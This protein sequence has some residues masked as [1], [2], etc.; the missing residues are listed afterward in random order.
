M[1]R[2]QVLRERKFR[3]GSG[4]VLNGGTLHIL[5]VFTAYHGSVQLTAQDGIVSWGAAS[6]PSLVQSCVAFRLKLTPGVATCCWLISRFYL[7]AYR[8][9]KRALLGRALWRNSAL[10]CLVGARAWCC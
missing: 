10:L 8:R 4:S 3:H 2:P 5:Y 7:S 9:T 6:P 1:L